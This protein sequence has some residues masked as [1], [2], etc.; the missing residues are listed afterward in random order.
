M[1]QS[2][3]NSDIHL[4]RLEIADAEPMLEWLKNPDIYEKMQYDPDGQNL[5]KCREFIQD[6]WLDDENYHY[7]VV[8]GKDEYLGTVS[9]KNVDVQNQT[10]ELGIVIHPKASGLGVGSEALRKI[11]EKAFE[12]LLLNKVYLYVRV[13][14][15]KAV[16]F[17]KR[18]R[19]ECEGCFK[20]HLCIRGVYKDI[21]WFSLRRTEYVNW[22]Y[23]VTKNNV[24]GG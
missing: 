18:N 22:K 9:L 17:Y 24:C 14:N 23:K 19:M 10:A 1:Y 20:E 16:N 6:S 11:M 21:L 3:L 12:E 5:E 13:D 15:E 4:R 7:A 2:I 8:N